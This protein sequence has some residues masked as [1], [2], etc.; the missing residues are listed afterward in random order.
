[1]RG[2]LWRRILAPAVAGV[3]AAGCSFEG[4]NSLSLPGTVGTGPDAHVYHVELENVGTLESNSPVLLND[5]VVGAVG[6]MRI[7]GWHARVDVSVRPDVVVPANAVATVGQTSLL[8]SMHLALDPPAGARP[9]GVLPPGS[10]IR[11]DASSTYPSTEQTLASLSALINGGGLGQ[12][13][14]VLGNA[15]AALR[16]RGDQVRD[17]LTRL[18][19]IAGVLESQ[20]ADVVES[21]EQLGRLS[22]DLAAQQDSLTRALQAVP[23]ALEVLIRQRPRIT[24]ALQ[25]LGELSRTATGLIHDTHTELVTNLQNLE[26]V[27]RAL[28]DVGPEL[29][30]VLAYLPTYPLSQDI[31]DRGVRGDYMNLFAVIDL[32]VPRLKRSALLGTRFGQPRT[33]LIPAPG[34]P[35]HLAYTY[36]PLGVPVVPVPDPMADPTGSDDEPAAQPAVPDEA[37]AATDT[38]IPAYDGAILPVQPPIFS[39]SAAGPSAPL[40]AGPYPHDRG[41]G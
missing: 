5:V 37:V 31:I 40:F 13:G 21:L 30:R 33:P 7:D 1:M 16:G 28:A 34:D 29:D 19:D 27:L 32:T 10:T 2:G 35:W 36:D 20:Q 26:P 12:I 24:T 22:G 8:G 39:M 6:R 23:P 17:V 4:L 38:G 41:G 14:E 9:E 18:N 11:L 3:L 15:E 25:K